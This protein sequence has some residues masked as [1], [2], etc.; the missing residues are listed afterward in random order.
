M[1]DSSEATVRPLHQ[2][3]FTRIRRDPEVLTLVEKADSVLSALGF[4]DHGR[5]HVTL[6][7]V[8]ASKLLADLGYAPLESDLAAVAGFLHDIGNAVGR[9]NHAA[10]GAVLAYNLLTARGVPHAQ[11]A[12]VMAAIGN[13]DELEHGVPVN[14]PSAALI[15]A[16]K[17]DIHRSRVRTRDPGAFDV[18]DRVNFSVVK[19]ELDVDPRAKTIKLKLTTDPDAPSSDIAEL[20]AERFA[21]SDE[22]ARFLDCAY[23]VLV[24]GRTVR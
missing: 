19:S 23:D 4:T 14:A 6:V 24:D 16:D 2:T 9:Y 22:A 12:D 8:T 20:F 7:A 5:R 1:K 13:H 10:S 15:I 11:A 18:H 3:L 17:A 21:M